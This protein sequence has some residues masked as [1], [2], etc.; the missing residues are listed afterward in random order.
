MPINRREVVEPYSSAADRYISMEWDHL[1][2]PVVSSA[3]ETD[4]TYYDNEATARDQNA[5]TVA[6]N[7]VKLIMERFVVANV[8][9]LLRVIVV[10]LERPIR[11]RS[12]NELD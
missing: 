10:F 4:V 9:E 2:P 11:R 7:L 8:T 3:S 1:M 6:P 12:Y 5:E